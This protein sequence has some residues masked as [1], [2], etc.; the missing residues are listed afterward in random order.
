MRDSPESIFIIADRFLTPHCARHQVF[1][2]LD[3]PIIC[4]L[5]LGYRSCVLTTG[6]TFTQILE[7]VV[8]ELIKGDNAMTLQ[9]RS[10]S[11]RRR[12]GKET[13]STSAPKEKASK[14]TGKSNEGSKS[15][16]K[17]TSESAPAEEPRQ[18]TQDLEEPSHQ[19]FETGV[20]DDQPIA[21]ASQHPEWFQI[22]KKPPTCDPVKV[23]VQL[24]SDRLPDEA[25]AENEDFINKLYEN[26][27]K[28]IKEQV[29]EQ[30]KVQVSKIL[31]K[32]KKTVNEQ[33][34]AEVLTRSSN[35]SNTSYVMAADLSEMELKKILI[36]KMESN[37]SIYRS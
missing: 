23:A 13:E 30:V 9:V 1:N 7:V 24:Q 16:H 8:D 34:E 2:P 18:T 22:Q 33:L 19:E 26:I 37:K 27:Q 12:E 6:G 31:S 5:C 4:Y 17:T 3:V 15:H 35:S 14:T 29:K 28:I 32:I 21:E 20:A 11:K 10:G 25:Q 36:E